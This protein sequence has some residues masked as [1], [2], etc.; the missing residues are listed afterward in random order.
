MGASGYMLPLRRPWWALV[1]VAMIGFGYVQEDTK[2]KLNHYMEVG[3]RYADFYDYG[4]EECAW[5]A[6]C[7]KMKRQEWWDGYA[8]LC[9]TNF[10]YSRDTFDV[11]HGWNGE[12]MLRAKWG[13]MAVIV[14]CFFAMDA[15]FLRAAGV[16]DRWRILLLIYGAAGLVVA[17]FWLVDGRGGAEDPGYNVAREVLGFLQSPMPSLMLVLLPWLRDK[18]L[19]NAATSGPAT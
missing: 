2:V 10:A 9:R 1:L 5:D 6:D 17:V 7:M 4:F 3:D 19:A 14:L 15:L 12:E 18:A 13:L 11:F 8:P 16:G